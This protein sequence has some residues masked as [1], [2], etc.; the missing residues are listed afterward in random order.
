M[1]NPTKTGQKKVNVWGLQNN[2]L[3]L[4][5]KKERK[6]KSIMTKTKKIILGCCLMGGAMAVLAL[7]YAKQHMNIGKEYVVEETG[8]IHSTDNPDKCYFISVAKEKGYTISRISKDDAIQE[9]KLICRECYPVDEINNYI[10]KLQ[11]TVT[12]SQFIKDWMVWE[13][14]SKYKNNTHFEYLYVYMD[15]TGKAHLRGNCF[16]KNGELERTKL[17]DVKSIESTCRVCVSRGYSDFIYKYLTTG[18]YDI[19]LVDNEE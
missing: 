4:H 15:H 1:E 2:V 19:S 11:V 14:M 10:N 17:S 8:Y 7:I 16:E 5:L 3:Y 13:M 9:E 6:L 18:K 12:K